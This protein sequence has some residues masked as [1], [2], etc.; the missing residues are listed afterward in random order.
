MREN[1]KLK[2]KGALG[3]FPR[4]KEAIKKLKYF[5]INKKKKRMLTAM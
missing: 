4:T 2:S 5:V 3:R 1:V